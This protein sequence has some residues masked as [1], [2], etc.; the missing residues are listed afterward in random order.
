[1]PAAALHLEV[2][3]A[4]GPR[5]LDDLG[6]RLD[7][8]AER[9]G[10]PITSRR[11]WLS[12]W[13]DAYP[14]AEPWAVSASEGGELVGACLLA[15]QRV[16]PHVHV[17]ALGQGR[18][19]RTRF[20]VERSEV[21][22]VIAQR[23]AV[24]L[25]RREQPWTLLIEQLPIAD[26]VSTALAERLPNADFLRGGSVPGVD[27]TRGSTPSEHL[28]KNLRRQLQKCRNRLVSDSVAATMSFTRVSST[29]REL[30]REIED[31]HRNRDHDVGRTSDIDDAA[32]RQ[33]WRNII[34][35]HIERGQ[36][37]IGTLRLDDALAAYVVS[38]IDHST[39]RVFDGRF[40][41]HWARYSPGRLL[42]T[43]A[44]GRAMTHHRLRQLDWM[45]SIASDKLIAANTSEP[46]VHLVAHSTF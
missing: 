38:F 9:V 39:Y 7:E 22:D 40:D 16:G 2:A 42:E 30:V 12:A 23:V 5:V 18:N 37:E 1:M 24:A 34:A 45:N 3:D 15:L 19:D 10:A 11:P 4:V 36:T 31:V 46:T 33:L 8:L 43:E 14:H 27:L 20:L 44:L 13:T 6:R 35:T 32:G 41:T 28:S 17:T 26:P 29:L 25:Q 21:A